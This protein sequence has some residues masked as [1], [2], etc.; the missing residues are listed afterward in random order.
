M[1]LP[2]GRRS[3]VYDLCLLKMELRQ[4][5]YFVAVADDLSFSK[6]AAR[7]HVAQPSVSEQ[8]KALER[9]FGLPLFN[10]TSRGVWLTPA[11]QDILPLARELL[12][13]A[14][15]LRGLAQLSARRL[16][17]RVRIGFLADEY[18]N[19]SGDRLMAL[20]RQRHPRI[21]IEF[22][23]VDF[24]EHHLALEGGQVD[25]AFVMGPVPSQFASVEI[26]RSPRL[27]AISRASLEEG[28]EGQLQAIV[29]R[30]AVVLPN[31]VISPE[32]RRSW[33]PPDSPAGGV[34]IVG[35]DSMEAMLASVGARRG[36]AIVPEYVSRYYPQPGVAFV[37]LDGLVECTVDFAALRSRQDEP[38][39]EALIEL[40]R[41]SVAT[42]DDA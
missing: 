30:Q 33:S 20:V 36:V 9:E 6:A 23:Q 26:A 10:R 3:G 42:T 1:A 32:W 39:I 27:L 16:S 38:L 4:L 5:E 12:A 41:E 11:G 2:Q 8:I 17:G 37:P 13:D 24:A 40:A 19:A 34:F 18:A 28:N 14:H 7:L 25:V 31:H 35:E 21:A 29:R 22:H 15:E